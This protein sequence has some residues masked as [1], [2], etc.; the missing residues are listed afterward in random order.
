[1]GFSRAPYSALRRWSVTSRSMTRVRDC[2]GDSAAG[3][4]ATHATVATEG[5]DWAGYKPCPAA[6]LILLTPFER[7]TKTRHHEHALL[8]ARTNE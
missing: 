7:M 6:A 4:G 1:M 3:R 2:F 8:R 5:D